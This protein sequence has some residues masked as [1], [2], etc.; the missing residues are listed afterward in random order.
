MS[1]AESQD[2]RFFGVKVSYLNVEE[3]LFLSLGFWLDRTAES[4][5]SSNPLEASDAT[6]KVLN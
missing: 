5:L 6:K 2:H 3:K 1:S 4:F